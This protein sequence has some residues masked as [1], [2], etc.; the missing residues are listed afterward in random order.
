MI[1]KRAYDDYHNIEG[2]YMNKQAIKKQG[3]IMIPP[4]RCGLD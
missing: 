2:K 3:G 4:Y 1:E